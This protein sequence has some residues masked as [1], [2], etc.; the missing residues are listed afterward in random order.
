MRLKS[1]M[2][3]PRL[4]AKNKHTCYFGVFLKPSEAL[5]LRAAIKHSGLRES[6]YI[7]KCLVD[8]GLGLSLEWLIKRDPTS[9]AEDAVCFGVDK[10][11]KPPWIPPLR[12]GT[13]VKHIRK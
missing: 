7:R 6:Q 2:G 4:E 9:R 13:W 8:A 10:W 1:K 5:N 3:R 12:A 11:I